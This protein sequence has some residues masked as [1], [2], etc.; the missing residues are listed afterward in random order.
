MQH[1]VVLFLSPGRCGTQWFARYLG[2][3]YGDIAHVEHEPLQ[4][5][6]YAKKFLRAHTQDLSKV[7]TSQGVLNHLSVVR[8]LSQTKMYIETGWPS[9]PAAPLFYGRFKENIS[10]VR[11]I[12][13]PVYHAFS[14]VS[15]G[16]YSGVINHP[17][18]K[19]MQLDPLDAGIKQKEYKEKW[20]RMDAFEKCLFF[21][22]EINLYIDEILEKFDQAKS[23]CV[24]YETVFSPDGNEILRVIEFLGLPIRREII[25]KLNVTVDEFDFMSRVTQPIHAELSANY[26]MEQLVK[27]PNVSILA[28]RLGYDLSDIDWEAILRRYTQE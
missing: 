2:E 11:I 3:V 26:V 17:F 1:P 13:H 21:W 10:F 22:M 12:R 23:I 6:Y 16:Y 25:S 20:D 24:Q 14:N 28:Q 4:A 15:H 19:Y 27:H 18:I 5:Y 7:Q 8:E 9:F